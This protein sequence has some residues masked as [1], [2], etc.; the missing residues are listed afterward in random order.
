MNKY[1]CSHLERIIG[2][3]LNEEIK[4]I[5]RNEVNKM[6][7]DETN[8]YFKAITGNR[9]MPKSELADCVHKLYKLILIDNMKI[10]EKLTARQQANIWQADFYFGSLC[11]AYLKQDAFIDI[12]LTATTKLYSLVT[13]AKTDIPNFFFYE[14]G[15]HILKNKSIFQVYRLLQLNP[16]WGSNKFSAK[17][18]INEYEVLNEVKAA[19][20]YILE[21]EHFGLCLKSVFEKSKKEL[22]KSHLDCL[23]V[24]ERSFDSDEPLV[25]YRIPPEFKQVFI[26]DNVKSDVKLTQGNIHSYVDEID[27]K[28]IPIYET[29]IIAS[30]EEK[31][32]QLESTYNQ[33]IQ[34]SEYINKK[35]VKK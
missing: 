5:I 14:D 21:N 13:D 9:D 23:Y 34:D 8:N 10:K 30:H 35:F 29:F 32:R 31:I 26:P 1:I 33:F 17:T 20:G 16:F 15:Y 12:N 25:N 4:D 22:K 6:S 2:Y 19:H 18:K 3:P 28:L 24:I 7:T 27:I 11:H